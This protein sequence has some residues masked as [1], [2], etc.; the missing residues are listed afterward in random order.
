MSTKKGGLIG[1]VNPP[2]ECTE[3]G[4]EIYKKN[5]GREYKADRDAANARLSE[6]KPTAETQF[7]LLKAFATVSG[8]TYVEDVKAATCPKIPPKP[9]FDYDTA[10]STMQSWSDLLDT[11][12]NLASYRTVCQMKDCENV[13]DCSADMGWG[14]WIER[15]ANNK[16]KCK[17]E[18]VSADKA[19]PRAKHRDWWTQDDNC[20]WT[21]DE[22]KARIGR[23]QR[24]DTD[25]CEPVC[26]ITC[27]PEGDPS[28]PHVMDKRTYCECG[29]DLSTS[30]CRE[31]GMTF[32]AKLCKCEGLSAKAKWEQKKQRA[33]TDIST[34]HTRMK[35]LSSRFVPP[36]QKRSLPGFSAVEE[37]CSPIGV[38]AYCMALTNDE[39]YCDEQ[40][41]TYYKKEWNKIQAL[42][43][44]ENDW[45]TAREVAADVVAYRDCLNKLYTKIYALEWDEF[46]P[47]EIN[48]EEC[49]DNAPAEAQ[50]PY[51]DK[52]FEARDAIRKHVDAASN[53]NVYAE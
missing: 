45:D 52:Y 28:K 14:K 49:E 13:K 4:E 50:L 38:R 33:L 35:E 7:K 25:I 39:D 22:N 27:P 53:C 15:D 43:K 26:N 37:N 36:S 51:I 30:K 21:C 6:L 1:H 48:E 46:Y 19:L 42:L 8:P 9:K 11:Y 31:L 2:D 20:K 29:C 23:G 44:R 5:T 12:A 17:C 16:V 3:K 10:R 24:L 18:C 41:A 34:E 47:P 40:G 32:N